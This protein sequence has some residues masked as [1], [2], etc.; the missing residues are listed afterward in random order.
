MT[1]QINDYAGNCPQCAQSKLDPNHRKAP[2]QSIDVS[3]PFVFWAMGYMGPLPETSRGNKHLLVAMDQFTNWCEVFATKDQRATT[4]ASLLV[5]RVFGRFG[6]PTVLHSDQG[7]NFEGN[8]MQEVCNIM[9][10]HKS[11]TTAYHPQCDKVVER[12]NRTLQDMLANFV[13]VHK[14]NWDLWVDLAVYAY[15]TSTHSST[16]FSPYELV[17]GK[18]PRTPVE[19]DLG[20]PLKNPVTQSEYSDSLWKHLH[21]IQ[22]VAQKQLVESRTDQRATGPSEASWHPLQVGHSVWLRRPKT[23][24]FGRRWICPYQILARNGVNY[25][26][27]SKDGK[28]LVV[29]HNNVKACT[30]PFGKGEP[31]CPVKETVGI[32]VATPSELDPGRENIGEEHHDLQ[33][34]RRPA[35]LRQIIRPPQRFGEFVTH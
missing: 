27:R 23:W 1:L 5:S 7:R 12:Q 24:K 10:I 4:V 8:L 16:G 13:S 33:P 28:E 21:S 22:K 32:E 19:L 26:V 35:R 9:G 20:L 18:V 11:R 6:P 17:S 25:R 3:E 34:F 31:F 29:H 14:D 30:V 15:S 2:L